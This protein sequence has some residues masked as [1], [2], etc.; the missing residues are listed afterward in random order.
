MAALADKDVS[1]IVN[2][3]LPAFPTFV[4]TQTASDRALPAGEL[5]KLVEDELARCGRANASVEV[6][7]CVDDALDAFTA[8]G[9]DVVAAGTITLAGE[10]A[11][12]LS[13]R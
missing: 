7:A 10:V 1:G 6:F 9:R 11:G 12:C 13:R 2:V 5:A 3:L 8:A 4:V